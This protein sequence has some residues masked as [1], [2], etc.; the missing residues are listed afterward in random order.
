MGNI[1]QQLLTGLANNDSRVVET[2]YS[3]VRPM[4]QRFILRNSGGSHDVE[5]I[6]QEV[7]V[8]MY[9]KAKVGQLELHNTSLTTYYYS[10]MRNIW[11]NHIRDKK[12]RE[13]VTNEMPPVFTVGAPV[14]PD[15]DR[16]RFYMF[17]QKH[18]RSL[19]SKCKFLLTQ[20]AN[21]TPYS[22][23]VLEHTEFKNEGQ[24]RVLLLRCR[25]RLLKM[26]RDDPDWKEYID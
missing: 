15:T 2:I 1:D 3:R 18:L 6:I 4:T 7:L 11:L 12:K 21:E 23:I 14:Q 16:E 17:V 5:D 9:Q 20:R 22:E 13:H 8:I 24:A 19:D 25:E 26:M 10:V